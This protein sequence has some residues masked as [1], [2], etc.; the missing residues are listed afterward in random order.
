MS[1]K[2]KPGQHGATFVGS[3]NCSGGM[4]DEPAVKLYKGEIGIMEGNKMSYSSKVRSL[5]Y[6]PMDKMRA[7]WAFKVMEGNSIFTAELAPY[8]KRYKLPTTDKLTAFIDL[9]TG[10][11]TWWG[12]HIDVVWRELLEDAEKDDLHYEFIRIG[13]NVEDVESERSSGADGYLWT[14][15][16]IECDLD[17][18]ERKVDHGTPDNECNP[19]SAGEAPDHEPILGDAGDVNAADRVAAERSALQDDGNGHEECLLGSSVGR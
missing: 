14:Q 5:I 13:E 6:G 10:D 8:I 3:R 19:E 1:E 15:R 7:F 18:I 17:N 9:N 16:T 4:I 12:H 2:E 11:G